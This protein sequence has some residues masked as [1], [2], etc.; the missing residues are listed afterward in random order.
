MSYVGHLTHHGLN[1]LA[2]ATCFLDQTS[3]NAITDR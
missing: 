2:T 1:V 3:K